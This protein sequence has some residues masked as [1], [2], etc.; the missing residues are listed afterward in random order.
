MSKEAIWIPAIAREKF[1]VQRTLNTC[2]DQ[3][4]AYHWKKRR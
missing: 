2:V 4:M 3:F 1:A